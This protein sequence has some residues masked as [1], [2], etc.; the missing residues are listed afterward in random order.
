MITHE[1]KKVAELIES[2]AVALL[3]VRNSK[4]II[5][6]VQDPMRYARYIAE[7]LRS[8]K[9]SYPEIPDSSTASAPG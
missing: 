2:I 3:S 7:D 9:A 6:P 5:I 1:D 8:T 4:G